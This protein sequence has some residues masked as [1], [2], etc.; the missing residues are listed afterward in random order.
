MN[1]VHPNF[2]KEDRALRILVAEQLYKQP[3]VC[4]CLS[5]CGFLCNRLFYDPTPAMQLLTGVN[6]KGLIFFS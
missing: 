3:C 4:V 5:V 2:E 1:E 6:H